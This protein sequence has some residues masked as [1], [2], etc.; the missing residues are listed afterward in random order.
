MNLKRPGDLKHQSPDIASNKRNCKVIWISISWCW[1][2]MS[3]KCPNL[4]ICLSFFRLFE[5]LFQQIF[6]RKM[7]WPYIFQIFP[8]VNFKSFQEQKSNLDLW[9]LWPWKM[10]DMTDWIPAWLRKNFIRFGAIHFAKTEAKI[11]DWNPKADTWRFL[12]LECPMSLGSYYLQK[13]CH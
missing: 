3:R 12:Y 2:S 11:P 5:H 8:E 4:N 10:P 1:V 13:R 9:P 6:C 7:M